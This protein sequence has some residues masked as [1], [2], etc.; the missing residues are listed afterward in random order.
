MEKS[1]DIPNIAMADAFMA[2]FGYKRVKPTDKE[3]KKKYGNRSKEY[4]VVMEQ[5]NDLSS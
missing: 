2:I 1:T 4:E 5:L 3:L